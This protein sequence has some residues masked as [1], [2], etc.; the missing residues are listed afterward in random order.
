MMKSL[1]SDEDNS[2]EG[3]EAEE[4]EEEPYVPD[5]RLAHFK[6]IPMKRLQLEID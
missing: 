1:S 2:K 4:E 6:T 3:E 5:P